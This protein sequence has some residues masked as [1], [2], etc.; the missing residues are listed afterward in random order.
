MVVQ[1]AFS[2]LLLRIIGNA[3]LDSSNRFFGTAL[4][5]GLLVALTAHLP[6]VGQYVH[7]NAEWRVFGLLFVFSQISIAALRMGIHVTF[8]RQMSVLRNPQVSTHLAIAEESGFFV[9]AFLLMFSTEQFDQRSLLVSLVPF[10][11]GLAVFVL[12]R[13]RTDVV[14][15]ETRLSEATDPPLL[16]R[17]KSMSDYFKPLLKVGQPVQSTLEDRPSYINLLIGLTS[18]VAF[19]KALQW[20]GMAYG[21][22]I[23]SKQGV[24]LFPLFSKMSLVQSTCTLTILLASLKFASKIPSWSL[25]FRVLLMAQGMMGLALGLFAAPYLLMGAEISRKVLEH[26]FLGRSLQLLTSAIPESQRFEVRHLMERRSTT[27][28]IAA[29]GLAAFLVMQ[30]QLAL[31]LLFLFAVI[32]AAV[33]LV[34][35]RRLFEALSDFHLAHLSQDRLGGVIQGA[36]ALANPENKQH[37]AALSTLL[38]L[39]PRPAIV[40]IVL[41][42]LGRMQNPAALPAI[43]HYIFSEREDI[44]LASVRALE[45]FEGHEINVTLLKILNDVIR[46]KMIMR[47]SVVR[48]LTKRLGRLAVAYLIELLEHSTTGRVCANSVEILGEI[49]IAENDEELMN[50]LSRFLDSTWPRRVRANATAA[51]YQHPIHGA[52]AMEVFDRLMIS[53]ELKDFTSFAFIAGTLNLRG[54]ESAIRSRSLKCEHKNPALLVALLRLNNSEAS[55]HLAHWL[56]DVDEDRA[57]QCL[58]KLSAIS[59]RQ[60]AIVFFELIER[61]PQLLDLALLRMRKSQLDFEADRD[62]IREEAR[63][64]GIEL[65][66]E[67]AWPS[68][69]DP[70]HFKKTG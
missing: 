65:T 49:A 56:V 35:R 70:T 9:G 15:R 12:L 13:A 29:A 34:L 17:L 14:K 20:F 63:R 51:L 23:A 60:R 24:M 61:W 4:S 68:N 31:E 41:H 53:P 30:G 37:H 32:M 58:E 66:E 39:H 18:V 2:W 44:Q 67:E 48:L 28:G 62:L 6:V 45:N 38:E 69:N 11:L 5:V 27:M 19:L 43:R 50:Y 22:S 57:S 8:S 55:T 33:G 7:E 10:A 1:A 64:L 47:L 52:K 59:V 16:D 54:H 36:Y 3:T 21:L 40:K 26:G 25:G 46:Q 42:A